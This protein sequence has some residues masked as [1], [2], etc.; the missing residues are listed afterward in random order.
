MKSFV[1]DCDCYL[2]EIVPL[3]VQVPTEAD[4]FGPQSHIV[5]EATQTPQPIGIN[6]WVESYAYEGCVIL[7]FILFSYLFFNFRGDVQQL[8]HF[9]TRRT[10]PEQIYA[11]QKSFC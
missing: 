8:F 10:S 7:I 2:S 9:L 3:D 5:T 6:S 4:I 1:T 11:E